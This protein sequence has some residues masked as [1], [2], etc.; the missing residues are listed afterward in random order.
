[1]NASYNCLDCHV[2]NGFGEQVAIIHD[3][4]LTSCIENVTYKQLLDEVNA[5]K[6][7]NQSNQI[8]FISFNSSK[9]SLFAGVLNKHGVKKGDR[10]LIYMPMIPQAIVAMLAS[11]RIG[12][13]HSLVFG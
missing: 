4:P 8:N 11:A 6:S 9:V 3:S 5:L 12:A 7:Y 1:L 10:V 2:K 13:I